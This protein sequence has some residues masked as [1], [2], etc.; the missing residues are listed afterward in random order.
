MARCVPD[1]G[2]LLG[3]RWFPTGDGGRNFGRWLDE[4]IQLCV[5]V[6]ASVLGELE[7]GGGFVVDCERVWLG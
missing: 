2:I 6:W 5:V 4:K 1:P 7:V 3:S